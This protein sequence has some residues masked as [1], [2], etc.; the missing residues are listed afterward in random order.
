MY[1]N[2]IQLFVP[3][4]YSITGSNDIAATRNQHL[5]SLLSAYPKRR[6][7]H[8]KRTHFLS[9]NWLTDNSSCRSS[10]VSGGLS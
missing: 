7:D 6:D 10:T 3:A 4:N 2:K 9:E 8:H 1:Q 5:E